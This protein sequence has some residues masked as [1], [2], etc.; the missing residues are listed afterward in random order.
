MVDVDYTLYLGS[1]RVTEIRACSV[2]RMHVNQEHATALLPK[3]PSRQ[4]LHA[5]MT[6]A[7]EWD[8]V[9]GVRQECNQ[10]C[11]YACMCVRACVRVYICMYVCMYVFMCVYV[12]TYVRKNVRMYVCMY[13]C[14]CVC[15][16][17][18]YSPPLEDYVP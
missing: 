5:A 15:M 18:L 11:R 1:S 10:P 6:S 2:I 16:H 7:E 17:S 12:C 14:M 8:G 4:I 3:S 13:A 9:E